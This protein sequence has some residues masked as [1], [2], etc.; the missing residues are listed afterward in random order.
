MVALEHHEIVSLKKEFFAEAD[1]RY[2]RIEECNDRQER[3]NG[4]LAK[5]DKRIEL[6]LQRI[7]G[8]SNSLNSKIVLNN[9]LTGGLI[10][11]IIGAVIAFYFMGG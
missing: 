4:I 7:E 11:A 6:M 5:D 10:T 8:V 9:W 1:E 2:V 3:F